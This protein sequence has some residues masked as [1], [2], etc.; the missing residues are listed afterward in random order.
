[1]KINWKKLL[2]CLALPLAVGGLASLLS[3]GMDLYKELDRP[4]LS[5]PGWVFPVV[6]SLLYLLMGYA[7][8]RVLTSEK[9]MAQIRGALRL[10]GIQLL[11]NFLWPLVFFGLQWRLAA[12]F[13]LLALWV[14]IF[15]TM[16]KFSKIDEVAGDLLLPYLVWVSFAGYLNF[17]TYLLNKSS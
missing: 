3:G 12:L 8:Y 9:E 16:R 1:M 13:V 15:L 6:W 5:P 14:L 17:G 4:P 11:V 2:L 10:Y 7:S